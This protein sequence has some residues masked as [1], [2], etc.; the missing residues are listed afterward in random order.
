MKTSGP[1]VVQDVVQQRRKSLQ[2]TGVNT[3]P[4]SSTP[5][6]TPA[7]TR[8]NRRA[9]G[10]GGSGLVPHP[11]R[12]VAL[13]SPHSVRKLTLHRLVAA[14]GDVT[15]KSLWSCPSISSRSL[16][17]AL[18]DMSRPNTPRAA[19]L[20]DAAR[21]ARVDA[22]RLLACADEAERLARDEAA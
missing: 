18:I 10:D 13:H 9:G 14:L 12:D 20:L 11:A 4:G 1:L 5:P 8:G 6:A 21:V 17:Y 3:S 22:A 19:Q 15:V 16:L 2:D 7:H